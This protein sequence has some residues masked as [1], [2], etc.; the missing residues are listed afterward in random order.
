MRNVCWGGWKV[1]TQHQQMPA[2]DKRDLFKISGK[3]G[4]TRI[5]MWYGQ[6]Q[7]ITENENA[8]SHEM[9]WSRPNTRLE[10]TTTTTATSIV[11]RALS[12][13]KLPNVTCNSPV[14]IYFLQRIRPNVIQSKMVI[15]SSKLN[16]R[17]LWKSKAINFVYWST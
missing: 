10:I 15:E 4:L 12:T 11:K 16:N 9:Q 8:I 2:I 6:T 7:G 1:M 13:W 5:N 17:M 3:Y 14:S